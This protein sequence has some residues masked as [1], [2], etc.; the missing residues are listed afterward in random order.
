MSEYCEILN[1]LEI[2]EFFEKFFLKNGQKSWDPQKCHKIGIFVHTSLSFQWE[3][4]VLIVLQI[5]Q[6]Q[7][8]GQVCLKYRVIHWNEN[9]HISQQS[10]RLLCKC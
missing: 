9:A 3:I 5:C 2:E 1:Y 10:M 6:G 4:Q 7:A 8:G